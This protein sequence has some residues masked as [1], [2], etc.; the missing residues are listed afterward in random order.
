M[1]ERRGKSTENMDLTH[2][3]ENLV[4]E[5]IINSAKEIN[6]DS[7]PKKSK[8]LYIRMYNS[9]VK[10]K[11]DNEIGQNVFSEDILI[12]YFSQLAGKF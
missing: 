9:F 11:A 1:R 12:V 6:L 10:W 2:E 7:L 8:D 5:H 4:P 3:K